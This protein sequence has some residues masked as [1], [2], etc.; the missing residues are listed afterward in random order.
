[1]EVLKY[2]GNNIKLYRKRMGI[3]Q[4]ELA[5]YLGVKREMI[6]YYE[7]GT[8]TVPLENMNKLADLFWI[9]LSDLMEENPDLQKANV[10]FAFRANEIKPE[11]MRVIAEFGKIVKNYIKLRALCEKDGQNIHLSQRMCS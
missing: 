11:D 9:D 1:M 5:E 10:A 4:E 2:I 3:R 8:R 7:N 6:S